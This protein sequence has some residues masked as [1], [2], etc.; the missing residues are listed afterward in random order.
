MTRSRHGS[1]RDGRQWDR[2][3]DGSE[4]R[5]KKKREGE[6][7]RG[8]EK[9]ERQRQRQRECRLRATDPD[10]TGLGA[11]PGP[12][13]RYPIAPSAE[14][15]GQEARDQMVVMIEQSRLNWRFFEYDID[16]VE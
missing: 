9:T 13:G 1:D 6:R 8:R 12:G 11:G 2:G 5:E 14:R 15:D 10:R 4:G 3:A 16:V 7:E